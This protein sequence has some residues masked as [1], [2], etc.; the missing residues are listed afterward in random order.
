M[1]PVKSCLALMIFFSIFTDILIWRQRRWSRFIIY[2]ELIHLSVHGLVPFNYGTMKNLFQMFLIYLLFL[3][4]CVD[5]LTNMASLLVFYLLLKLV[6]WPVLYDTEI[7][8]DYLLQTA[9]EFLTIFFTLAFFTIN[10]AYMTKIHSKVNQ[11]MV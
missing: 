4:Y 11:L 3:S 6:Q 8:S 5:M 2:F 10:V 1:E 9:I 7:D